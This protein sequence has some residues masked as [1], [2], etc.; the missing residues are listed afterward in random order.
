M[1]WFICLDKTCVGLAA[2]TYI[3]AL[4]TVGYN[5]L[6]ISLP[7][8]TL[9]IS[10]IATTFQFLAVGLVLPSRDLMFKKKKKWVFIVIANIY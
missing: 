3:T 2:C 4:N 10:R 5:N 6:F 7:N 9:R 8:W 1:L